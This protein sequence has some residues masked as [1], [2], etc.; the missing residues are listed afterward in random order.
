MR[1]SSCQQTF[2]MHADLSSFS[3]DMYTFRRYATRQARL[4]RLY[5]TG[6]VTEPPI[7]FEQDYNQFKALTEDVYDH[8]E[9]KNLLTD[10]FAF[11]NYIIFLARICGRVVNAIEFKNHVTCNVILEALFMNYDQALVIFDTVAEQCFTISGKNLILC[12]K[13]N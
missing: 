9:N 11:R 2:N 1:P 12:E 3:Y 4:T 5:C 10:Y 8:E 13:Y 6:N 7:E